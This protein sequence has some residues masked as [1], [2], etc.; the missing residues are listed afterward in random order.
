MA[1]LKVIVSKLNRR[2][3]PITDFDEKRNVTGIVLKGFQFVSINEEKNALG[4]WYEDR[5][6]NY[7]WG[8][9]LVLLSENDPLVPSM[10]KTLAAGKATIPLPHSIPQDLPLSHSKCLL[11]ADWLQLHYGDQCA[12]AVEGTPFTKELL[13][14]IA[15]QESAIYF[16]NWTR[17]HTPEEVLGRCV[18][19]ASGDVHGTRSAFPKNT[20][21]FIARYGNEKA[22]LLIA[23]AN[24]TRALRGFGPK[25]WVYAGYGIFQYDIQYIVN[26]EA[27]FLQ[28]QWY[29]M[30]Y[31]LEKVMKELK[32]KWKDHPNDLFRT[33]R[34]YNGSGARAE[35]YANNVLQFL[36]WIRKRT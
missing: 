7:Y 22:N 34:A 10:A 8:G 33:I 20:A 32:S 13:Y 24:K 2:R 31:C 3:T 36:D 1:Q 23:E 17:D 14:A 29:E 16:F 19:D 28:K 4:T 11:T 5:D 30:R 25:N 18:F 6:G 12:Q 15:C 26:D 35:N 9:G 21:A 27:F